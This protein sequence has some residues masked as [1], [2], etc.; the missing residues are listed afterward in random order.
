MFDEVA[1]FF[2]ELF[3]FPLSRETEIIGTDEISAVMGQP[4][5]CFSVPPLT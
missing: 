2:I 5:Y 3:S 4:H 1:S